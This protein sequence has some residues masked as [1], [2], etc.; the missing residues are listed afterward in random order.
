MNLRKSG[1][2]LHSSRCTLKLKGA[3]YKSYVRPAIQC[4][5]E[6]WYLKESEM[7]ILQK[8]ERSIVRA[9]CGVQLKDGKNLRI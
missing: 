3:I 9:M 6:A 2:L 8:T 5:S 7:G 1:E 4:G